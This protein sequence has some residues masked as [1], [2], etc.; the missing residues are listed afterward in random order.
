[1]KRILITGSNGLLGQKL[2]HQLLHNESYVLLATSMGENRMSILKEA[3][4]SKNYQSLD[5]TNQEEVEKVVAS[6]KPN[7]IINTAAM[8]NVD[9]CETDH[10]NCWKL[11]VMAVENLIEACKKID[12]HLI[13]LSTDFVFDGENGPYKEEDIAVP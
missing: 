13:H 6:F 5:I 8:T 1:M 9:A 2:V 4:Y 12:A 3:N 10:D 11:N 7:V